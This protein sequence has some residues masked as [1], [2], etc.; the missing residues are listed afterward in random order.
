MKNLIL[1]ILLSFVVFGCSKNENNKPKKSSF[2]EY[3]I[4]KWLNVKYVVME[5]QYTIAKHKLL[6]TSMI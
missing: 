6:K 4:G 5:E 2:P 3:L 1:I